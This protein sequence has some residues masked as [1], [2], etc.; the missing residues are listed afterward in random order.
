MNNFNKTQLNK[1]HKHIVKEAKKIA[2]NPEPKNFSV[3]CRKNKEYPRDVFYDLQ[4]ALDIK[5]KKGDGFTVG[6]G[7]EGGWT[8][9]CESGTSDIGITISNNVLIQIAYS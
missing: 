6:A 3:N 7:F 5:I 2:L 1:I 4:N 8:K 9:G